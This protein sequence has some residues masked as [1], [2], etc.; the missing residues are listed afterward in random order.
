MDLKIFGNRAG[1]FGPHKTPTGMYTDFDATA[2]YCPRC[3]QAVPVRKRF[4]LV[5]PEGDK[6][7]YLCAYCSESVGTKIDRQE[8]PMSIVV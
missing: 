3:K 4:L 6:Y 7:E 5:I 8:K 2:L 1:T